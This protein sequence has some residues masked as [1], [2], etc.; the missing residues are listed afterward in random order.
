[1]KKT[2]T[3]LALAV[4]LMA[5]GK[6]PVTPGP[7]PV[8]SQFIGTYDLHLV[9]D[10]IMTLDG[11]WVSEEFYEEF[12]HKTNPPKDGRLT[13]E[14]GQNGTLIVTATILTDGDSKTLFTTEATEHDGILTLSDCTSDYYR[15]TTG[16][17]THFTFHGFHSSLPEITFKS[18]Y[19]V[20]DFSYLITLTCTRR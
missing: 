9:Y 10:S 2:L 4:L 17:S 20:S 18:I 8:D 7:E 5:C 15:E 1:M 19:T 3:I 13:I 16:V 14:P 12:V 11:E 6:T